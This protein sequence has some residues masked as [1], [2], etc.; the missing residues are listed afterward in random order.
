MCLMIARR[1]VFDDGG[2]MKPR[3]IG[4]SRI[5]HVRLRRACQALRRLR[6]EDATDAVVAVGPE[7]IP[8]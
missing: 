8:L 3:I 6:I 2:V 4:A 1:L 7:R 5:R